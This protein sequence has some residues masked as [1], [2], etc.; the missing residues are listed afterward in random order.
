MGN[1]TLRFDYVRWVLAAV[2]CAVA[3]RLLWAM[4]VP[5]VPV[6]DSSAYDVFARNIAQHGVY[7][8][9]PSS[10]SAYWAVGTAAIYGALYWVFGTDTFF[11]HVAAN[12]LAGIACVI[13]ACL[14]ATHW[15]G[16]LAGILTAFI[17]AFWPAQV[18]FT[19]VLAS[20]LF[21]NALLL[22][23]IWLVECRTVNLR[24]V[25]F[26]SVL[27]GLATYIKPLALLV[28]F[29]FL[30]VWLV[31]GL[32]PKQ[33]L[34]YALFSIVVV[35]AVV[36]P[37]SYRNTTV[38]GTFV[39][40]ST[41]GG[42]NLW[43]GNNPETTGEYQPL[44]EATRDMSEVEREA[45]LKSDAL[46]YI[47]AEPIAFLTRSLVKAVRLYER[48]TIGVAWNERAIQ[49]MG[50]DTATLGAKI[51][52]QLYYL[53]TLGLALAGLVVA[54][55]RFGIAFLVHPTFL[56]IAYVTG[57]HAIIVIQDRYHFPAVPFLAALA[58]FAVSYFVEFT[59][60]TGAKL[61]EQS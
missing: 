29:G 22:A 6:S 35:V 23:A 60:R 46:A 12:F 14:L 26:A 54:F 40:L 18:M 28:P 34:G 39:F 33:A 24:T 8:W 49:S 43:M 17:M 52:S 7:G 11:P 4:L 48:E 5:V 9:E 27:L 42:T 15:F 16:K 44:P 58:G 56:M 41:N 61:E 36:S 37:W 45:A 2:L 21:F 1:P 32:R 20:E 10:P 47:R 53:V 57:V 3:V 55:Y 50:G 25:F 31:R 38:F 51:V 13:F 19:T 30:L 59:R